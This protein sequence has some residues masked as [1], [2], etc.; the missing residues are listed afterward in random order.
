MAPKR[1]FGIGL[2]EAS[3]IVKPRIRN[4]GG[5]CF[6]YG[7]CAYWCLVSLMVVRGR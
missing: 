2:E 7:V 3:L 5:K 1:M 6:Q 4:Y